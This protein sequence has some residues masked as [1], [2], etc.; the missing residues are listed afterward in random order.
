MSNPLDSLLFGK[1][2]EELEELFAEMEASMNNDLTIALY[3]KVLDLE[4][5]AVN[6]Y[7]ARLATII[8]LVKKNIFSMSEFNSV[9]ETLKT[10]P[11]IKKL[12]DNIEEERSLFNDMEGTLDE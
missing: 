3:K 7:R 12:Y 2:D 5:L 9:Y 11:E 6:N 8:L 10:A 1:S 4:E